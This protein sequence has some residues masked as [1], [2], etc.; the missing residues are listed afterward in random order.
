MF[1]PVIMSY[2]KFLIFIFT[3]SNEN[4]QQAAKFVKYKKKFGEQL[5]IFSRYIQKAYCC[6]SGENNFI[7]IISFREIIKLTNYLGK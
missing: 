2:C 6:L 7:V 3:A 1:V 5:T 4:R